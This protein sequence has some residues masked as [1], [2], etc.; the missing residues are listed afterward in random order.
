MGE[1]KGHF[2]RLLLIPTA[3]NPDAH[4]LGTFETKLAISTILPDSNGERTATFI[5][6]PD[7]INRDIELTKLKQPANK[8]NKTR[9]KNDRLP[10][11]QL[12]FVP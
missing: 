11:S 3:I 10:L 4:L 12:R 5:N 9:G 1:S 6:A 8:K 2:S 7:E